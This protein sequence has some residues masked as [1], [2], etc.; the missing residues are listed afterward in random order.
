MLLNCACEQYMNRRS[1]FF[2]HTDI[3]YIQN[4]APF[5]RIQI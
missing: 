2:L 1:P 3:W 5:W 4:G